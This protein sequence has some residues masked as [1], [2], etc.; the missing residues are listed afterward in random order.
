MERIIGFSAVVAGIRIAWKTNDEL[1]AGED[2][3]A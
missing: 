1:V 2:G 3:T